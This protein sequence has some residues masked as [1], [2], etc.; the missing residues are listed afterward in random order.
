MTVSTENRLPETQQCDSISIYGTGQVTE[1]G[2][3][4]SAIV[5]SK[6]Y[7]LLSSDFLDV[8][9][10]RL[11]ENEFTDARLEAAI[12]HVIDTCPYPTP[13]IANFISYDRHIEFLS[14]PQM[15]KKNDELGGSGFKY[16]KAVDVGLSKPKYASA[17]DIEKYN[18]KLWK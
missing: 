8:L 2:W 11:Q 5:L 7:P 12:K 17:V 14:Y 6:T 18:L 10:G 1:N 4:K 16:Y 15:L 3:K 13:T 9:H